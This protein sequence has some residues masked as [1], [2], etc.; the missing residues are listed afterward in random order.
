MS[1]PPPQGYGTPENQP[2]QGYPPP[3]PPAPAG[4]NITAVVVAAIVVAGGVIGAAI[5]TSGRPAPAAASTTS[6][7][8]PMPLAMQPIAAPVVPL[9]EPRAEVNCLPGLSGYQCSVHHVQGSI[10]LNVCWQIVA[11]CENGTRVTA[12][13]CQVVQVAGT[14]SRLIPESAIHNLRRCDRVLSSSMENMVITPA[15]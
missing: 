7:V 15:L 13:A 5:L 3:Q 2:T 6:A 9:V 1:Y 10:P 14:A 12:E 4:L 8:A 11:L